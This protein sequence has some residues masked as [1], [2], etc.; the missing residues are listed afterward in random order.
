MEIERS[1]L[2]LKDGRMQIILKIMSI[3]GNDVSNDD[4][5]KVLYNA[6]NDFLFSTEILVVYFQ[7]LLIPFQVTF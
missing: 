3:L 4:V 2:A 6:I 7:I 1:S 5:I